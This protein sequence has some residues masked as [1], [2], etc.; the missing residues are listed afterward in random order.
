MIAFD[1][2]GHV[3]AVPK[4]DTLTPVNV[5]ADLMAVATA[6]GAAT[7]AYYGYSWLALA[8][9]QLATRT[10]RLTTLAM[11][12][13]PP[14]SG[15]YAEMLK[16]TV[17][18]HEMAVHPRPY[19][20]APQDATAWD[21]ADYTLSAAQTRQFVTLYEAL[22]TFDDRAALARLNCHRLCFVGSADEITY[23][24]RWGDVHVSLAAPTIRLRPELEALGWQV[25]VLDGLDHVA[26]MQAAVVLPL[27]RPWLEAVLP[28]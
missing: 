15:P 8:G 24:E 19:E 12:G 4:P 3:L 5:C 25:H 22:Q 7:F 17:A 14:L 1:Y 10:D 11:G 13:Y 28:A 2:E 16:V 21:T 27:L 23:G 6:G 20:G 9:L 18:A 26:A